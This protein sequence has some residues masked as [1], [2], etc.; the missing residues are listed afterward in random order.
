LAGSSSRQLA[1]LAE[2][3]LT[4]VGWI[5]M[6]EYRFRVGDLVRVQVSVSKQPNARATNVVTLN[7]SSGIHE[8]TR[9]LPVPSGAEPLYQVKGCGGQRECVVRESELIPATRA[10]QPR[11]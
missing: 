10:P 2:L 9:L 3:G 5:S 1:S 7:R 6:A 11:H 8:V 4:Y